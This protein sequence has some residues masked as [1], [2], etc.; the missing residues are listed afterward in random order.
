MSAHKIHTLNSGTANANAANQQIVI[1]RASKVSPP[2]GEGK[3]N[4]D[5]PDGPTSVNNQRTEDKEQ[6]R[7]SFNDVSTS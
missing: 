5:P 7:T 1:S 6:V 4:I 3:Q 2:T